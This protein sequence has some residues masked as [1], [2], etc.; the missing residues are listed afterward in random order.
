MLEID[1]RVKLAN[2]MMYIKVLH[3]YLK[4]AAA[5]RTRVKLIKDK[6]RVVFKQ[7]LLLI[8]PPASRIFEK[9][10]QYFASRGKYLIACIMVMPVV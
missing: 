3:V 2:Q 6:C 7:P 1:A 4:S 9:F 5:Y 10:K 8:L